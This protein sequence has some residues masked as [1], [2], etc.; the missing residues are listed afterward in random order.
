[1]D[2]AA[3]RIDRRPA[4]VS[5]K[6][7]RCRDE[8]HAAE[9]GYASPC[10]LTEEPENAIP[11]QRKHGLPPRKRS[12]LR[13][14]RRKFATFA[15]PPRLPQEWPWPTAREPTAAWFSPQALRH[16]RDRRIPSPGRPTL[17]A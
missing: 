13:S 8:Y 9:Y 11:M 6:E 10:T 2:P 16:R 1:L 7:K 5:C 4:G 3:L 12:I 14:D 15:L 17:Q